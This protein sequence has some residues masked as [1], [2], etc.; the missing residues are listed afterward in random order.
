MALADKAGIDAHTSDLSAFKQHGGK[1]L[2]YHGWADPAIPPG[3]TVLYYKSVLAAMGKKQDDKKQEPE[4]G[5]LDAPVHGPRHAALQ[6]R[7]RAPI[8]STRWR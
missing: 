5:S 6:R 1:L 4:T 8:S 7:H 3:N 2:L